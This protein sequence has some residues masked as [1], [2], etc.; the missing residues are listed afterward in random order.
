MIDGFRLDVPADEIVAHLERRVAHHR[1]R[2]EACQ[3]RLRRLE[4]LEA[5]ADE[6][7]D[8]EDEDDRYD[9]WTSARVRGIER[10]ITLHRNREAFL[11]FARTHVVATEVYR[12]AADDLRLLEWL[13][14]EELAI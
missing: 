3:S 11:T 5:R 6:D 4:T 1:E 13:P 2:T 9:T 8:D 14:G 7:E 12:L 10:R